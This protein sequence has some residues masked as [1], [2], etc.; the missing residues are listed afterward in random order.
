[1]YKDCIW[2]VFISLILILNKVNDTYNVYDLGNHGFIRKTLLEKYNL[3]GRNELNYEPAIIDN[4]IPKF[5]YVRQK[6]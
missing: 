2:S 3:F 6:Y 4:G 1:M 5:I